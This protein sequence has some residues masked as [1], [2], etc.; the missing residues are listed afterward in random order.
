MPGNDPSSSP[1]PLVTSV[2]R[3]TAV[4]VL[5]M[6]PCPPHTGAAH[7]AAALASVSKTRRTF[8]ILLIRGETNYLQ[9]REHRQWLRDKRDNGNNAG[10]GAQEQLAPRV[11]GGARAGCV[12]NVPSVTCAIGGNGGSVKITMPKVH[13]YRAKSLLRLPL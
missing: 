9:A 1:T 4:R 2:S 12:P 10:S 3:H 13:I 8:A 5:L 11:L 7:A 6:A